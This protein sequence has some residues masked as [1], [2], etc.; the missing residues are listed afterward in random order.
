MASKLTNVLY[1]D[2]GVCEQNSFLKNIC[3]DDCTAE[4]A[5][6]ANNGC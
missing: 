2:G 5:I 1:I 6:I 4:L 3:V